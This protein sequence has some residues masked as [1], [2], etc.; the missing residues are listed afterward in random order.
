MR[1]SFL[2]CLLPFDGCRL[3]TSLSVPR[4]ILMKERN[5]DRIDSL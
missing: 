1:K 4:L 5:L 3:V 2:S